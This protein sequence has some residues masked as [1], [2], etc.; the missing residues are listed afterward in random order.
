MT[1]KDTSPSLEPPKRRQQVLVALMGLLSALYLVNPGAGVLELIPDN[2][3]LI[4]NLDEATA[5]AILLA[6]L[7]YYGIDLTGWLRPKKQAKK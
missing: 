1:Q 5:V 7:R 4:G 2:L 6:A 3:P